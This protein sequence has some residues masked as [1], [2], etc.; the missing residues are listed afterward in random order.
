M[1]REGE[2]G[3]EVT[4]PPGTVESSVGERIVYW[5]WVPLL[6]ILLTAFVLF[7]GFI[8]PVSPRASAKEV[9][10]FYR[11][12]LSRI[13]YSMILFN[14][15]GVALIP[16]V[17]LIAERMRGMAHRTPVIR[18]C[19]IAVA[20][21]APIVFLTST[22]FW[23]VAAFRPD[24]LP[25]LTLLTNDLAWMSFTCG[26]PFLVALFL[27]IALAVAW[28]DQPH[29]VFPRWFAWFNVAVAAVVAPAG[30]AGLTSSGVFAWDGLVS[31]WVKN[32]AF[33][34][35]IVVMAVVLRP[36]L[37][38]RNALPAGAT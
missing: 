20:G 2:L 24:R 17:M 30:F 27:F 29:P 13:R 5:T 36:A 6:A 11:G 7:P 18:Y 22:V 32:V 38:R 23:L 25:E 28:D 10:A 33:A 34:V 35:W 1:S 31:F 16:L 3:S 4:A 12:D 9:A 14:W 15:F 19:V 21:G 8:S 37:E 26:V